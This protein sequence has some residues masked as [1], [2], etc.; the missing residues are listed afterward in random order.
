MENEDFM[1]VPAEA[2]HKLLAW[3]GAVDGQ[4]QLER[5]VMS[6]RSRHTPPLILVLNCVCVSGGGPAQH[7]EGGG[8]SCRGLPLSP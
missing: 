3:Y 6:P 2:W 5:K 4:P 8:L 7:P 1:L